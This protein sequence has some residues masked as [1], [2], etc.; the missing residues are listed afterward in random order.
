[1]KKLSYITIL[2]VPVLF[3]LLA[4]TSCN[5]TPDNTTLPVIV[6]LPVAYSVTT[7]S[8]QVQAII[9]SF[10]N[11]VITA[12]G[13][14]Y[15]STNQSPTVSDLHTTNATDSLNFAA[16]IIGL[17]PNTTYYARS[18]ATNSA[19]TGYGSVISFKTNTAT[20]GLT[21]T[22]STFAGKGT[23]GYV[24]GA[25]TIAQ[26]Y[27]LQG[28]CTDASGNV[29][30]ADSYNNV[31]RKITPLGVTSTFAGN[32]TLGYVDGPSASAEFYNPQGIAADA[33]GNI[34][35]SDVGDNLI[36]KITSAGVV[37][38]LAGR[39]TAG[40]ADGTGTSAVFN[41][42]V[43]IAVDGSGNVYVADKANNVIRMIT[44]AGVVSTLAGLNTTA[45]QIDG[46]GTAATF[47]SPTGVA[48]DATGNIYVADQGSNAI[49][50]IT[51]GGVV[52]TLIGTNLLKNALGVPTGICLDKSGNIYITD[53]NGRIL[54]ISNANVL[55]SLAG[56]SGTTGFTNG[57]NTNALFNNPLAIAADK[58]GN[59]FVTDYYNNV[60]CK[61][62]VAVQP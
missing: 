19:G 53:T 50:K 30:V 32:G 21:A 8:A 40:Y 9:T 14:C 61:I 54:E 43:G 39:G 13:M 47:N 12:N 10:G 25:A 16:N 20:F 23:A 58:S 55:Y 46:T 34:Y 28:A 49:R 6:T 38:T 17:S 3:I 24:D 51:S 18:Y 27:N 1:M 59:I 37:S 31:I 35:V 44:P 48:V 7:T 57:T 52:T 45:S 5:K 60:I 4:L 15:S 62:T 41:K 2:S 11:G 36:R 42:P 26:F 56:I 22:V 29:Y 33:S